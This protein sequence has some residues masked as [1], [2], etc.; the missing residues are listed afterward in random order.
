MDFETFDYVSEDL[1]FNFLIENVSPRAS[2]L[3]ACVV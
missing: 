3:Q 1:G 2:L